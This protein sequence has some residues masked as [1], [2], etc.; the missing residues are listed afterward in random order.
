M[1]IARELDRPTHEF[2]IWYVVAEGPNAERQLLRGEDS[3]KH[4]MTF[5]LQNTITFDVE[6]KLK[7]TLQEPEENSDIHAQLE[8]QKI[9]L[10]GEIED[11]ECIVSLSE[12]GTVDTGSEIMP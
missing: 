8:E 12:T 1:A 11:F 5:I 10:N 6:D 4:A 2:D 7:I 3:F 9:D